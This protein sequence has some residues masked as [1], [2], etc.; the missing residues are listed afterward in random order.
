MKIQ[1]SWN[2][3]LRHCLNDFYLPKGAAE[4]SRIIK[5]SATLW[6]EP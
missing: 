3:T 2:A 5:S 6:W 4:C 1:G